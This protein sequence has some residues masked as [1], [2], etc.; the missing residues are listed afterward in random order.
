MGAVGR[1][2]A[3]KME[4]VKLL[5]KLAPVAPAATAE[6][7]QNFLDGCEPVRFRHDLQFEACNVVQ[8]HEFWGFHAS[9]PCIY[10]CQRQ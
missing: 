8:V 2:V 1:A 4:L 3:R 7:M 10:S 5:E 6:R 9:L